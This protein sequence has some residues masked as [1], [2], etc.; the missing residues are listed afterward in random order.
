MTYLRIRQDTPVFP[1]W[2]IQGLICV[3]WATVKETEVGRGSR[4]KNLELEEKKTSDSAKRVE[5]GLFV[6]D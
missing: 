1:K 2:E 3:Y 4:K 5:T 6:D